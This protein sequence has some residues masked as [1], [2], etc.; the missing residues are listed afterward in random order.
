MASFATPGEAAHFLQQVMSCYVLVMSVRHH[1][2]L[3]PR[4]PNGGDGLH[5]WRVASSILNKQSRTFDE[6]WSSSLRVKHG[7]NNS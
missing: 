1:G 5:I 6:G 2:K 3:C 7:D 4:V